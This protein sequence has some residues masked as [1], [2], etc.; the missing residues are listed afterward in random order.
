MKFIKNSLFLKWSLFQISILTVVSVFIGFMIFTKMKENVKKLIKDDAEN[1]VVTYQ[2]L[3]STHSDDIVDDD[4]SSTALLFT[5]QLANVYNVTIIDKDNII[6]SDSK[7]ENNGSL[8]KE[9]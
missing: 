4:I 7:I 2:G 9:F 6:I 1:I 5:S 3:M 8:Y